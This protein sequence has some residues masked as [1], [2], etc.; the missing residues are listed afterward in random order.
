MPKQSNKPK[1]SSKAKKTKPKKALSPESRI[2]P[3]AKA[4]PDIPEAPREMPL[5]AAKKRTSRG[6][7]KKKTQKR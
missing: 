5:A 4:I 3:A 1:Q 7:G 2:P 6:A